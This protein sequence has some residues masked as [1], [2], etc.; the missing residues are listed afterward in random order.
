MKH[1]FKGETYKSQVEF[2]F[3][4]LARE[5][6]EGLFDEKKVRVLRLFANNPK[7]DFY[8]REV[9]RECNV[10][11]AT[12][13]RILN[14]LVSMRLITLMQI[15]KSKY[16]RLANN[17]KTD[18]LRD[19]LEEKKNAIQEFTDFVATLDNVERII[20]HGKESKDKTNILIIGEE[21]DVTSIK[22]KVGEIKSKFNISIIELTLS[23]IQFDQMTKMGLFPHKKSVLWAKS[24]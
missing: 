24:A 20:L 10:S 21:L 23:E 15:K 11:P 8:L 18:V 4:M 22:H 17:D 5:V 6:L 9:A 7:E 12:T 3:F 2:P 14:S 16:Y 19:M 13:M 1:C